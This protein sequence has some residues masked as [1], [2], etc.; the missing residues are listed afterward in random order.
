MT[1]KSPYKKSLA[2]KKL[3]Q[4]ATI[5][6]RAVK[7]EVKIGSDRQSQAQRDYQKAIEQSGG[8]Y[9]IASSFEQF[10]DWYN[11]KFEGDE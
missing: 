6:G 4:M 9:F 8:I 11:V 5:D 7:I 3:E 10:L 2:V 1:R